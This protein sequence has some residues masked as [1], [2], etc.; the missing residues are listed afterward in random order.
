MGLELRNQY[1]YLF[2]F[3]KIDKGSKVIIYGA[4]EIGQEYY[5][6][7]QLT[8][9]CEIVCFADRNAELYYSEN[10][11]M[12]NRVFDIEFDFLLIALKME[13]SAR[14]VERTYIKGGIPKDKII[15]TGVRM[16]GKLRGIMRNTLSERDVPQNKEKIL[17][18]FQYGSGLGDAI[19]KKKFLTA[20]INLEK[21]I[22]IDIF[23]P[24]ASKYLPAIYSDCTCI[25]Q[26]V[27]DGGALYVENNKKYDVAISVYYV[28]K[29]DYLNEEALKRKSESFYA[30]MKKMKSNVEDYNI[31]PFP[32]SQLSIHFN[33]MMYAGKNVYTM[34]NW[35]DE[36]GVTDEFVKIPLDEQYEKKFNQL[37]LKKYITFNYGSGISGK[38][39]KELS[40]KQWP[41]EYFKAFVRMFKEEYNSIEI[42]Q[43]GDETTEQIEGADRYLLGENL[44]LVKYILRDSLIHLDIEGGL[45]H[46]AS[47]LGTKCAVLFG[48][49]QVEMLGYKGNINLVSDK[50]NGCYALYNE[51][52]KCARGMEKPE[53]MYSLSPQIVMG[54]IRDYLDKNAKG[55]K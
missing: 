19:I 27:D 46:L 12:P 13:S 14:D 38:N 39:N 47:Q 55:D 31:L 7:I 50:C 32:G 30:L 34:Y 25:N 15:Y 29:F 10:V 45:V 37:E 52:W 53:C 21:N 22:S 6:Q 8:N 48:P 3:E 54:H 42:I 41:V 43:L 20:F 23:S 2:P 33:R 28:L 36:L 4:G 49:T 9:Y 44:E 24:N 11:V 16:T 1:E 40:S 26:Y 35:I 17:V 5:K 18:A 51:R